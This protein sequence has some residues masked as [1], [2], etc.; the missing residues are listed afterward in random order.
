MSASLSSGPLRVLDESELAGRRPA[1]VAEVAVHVR[2][3]GVP[4]RV[5]DVG[6]RLPAAQQ[7]DRALEAQQPRERLRRQADLAPEAL[8]EVAAAP[9]GLAREL[10]DADGPVRGDEAGVSDR[11]LGRDGA[12][13]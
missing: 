6:E 8:G 4:A 10:L 11:D 3:V 7:R 13:T 9:A 12:G 2:L 1:E 5:G